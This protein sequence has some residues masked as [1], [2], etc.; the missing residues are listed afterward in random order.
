MLNVSEYI[1]PIK[2]PTAER[3]TVTILLRKIYST[4]REE[5]FYTS[6]A[7]QNIIL[8][9]LKDSHFLLYF[10]SMNAERL[11]NLP[12]QRQQQEFVSLSY[13]LIYYIRQCNDS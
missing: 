8:Q 2:E 1:K 10:L 4:A 6:N 9:S 3:H 13:R 11:L 7:F 5:G 12:F